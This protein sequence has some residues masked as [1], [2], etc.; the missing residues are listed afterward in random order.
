MA[1]SDTESIPIYSI[2][3]ILILLAP[4]LFAASIYMVLGR[5]I[6]SLGAEHLSPIRIKWLTK[7][8]VIGDVVAFLGQAAG[9]GIMSS[10]SASALHTGEVVTVAGL[11]VQLVFFSVFIIVSFVFHR[12]FKASTEAAAMR[13]PAKEMLRH[14]NWETVL[15][16]LYAAS[17]LILIRSVF[18]LIEFAMG[19][20]GV[21]LSNEVYAYLFDA[22]LIDL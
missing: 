22:T 4:A 15:Y 7:I 11:A 17:A 13:V 18:R 8:F 9:G 16:V 19:N 14:R 5:L 1:H 3:T 21:L 10:G 20:D 6:V 2:Q 12:R